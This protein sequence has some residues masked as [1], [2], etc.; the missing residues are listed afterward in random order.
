MRCQLTLSPFLIDQTATEEDYVVRP[1][2]N[3]TTFTSGMR[4]FG[5]ANDAHETNKEAVGATL[6]VGSTTELEQRM[7]PK[8][9]DASFRDSPWLHFHSVKALVLCTFSRSLDSITTSAS[10]INLTKLANQKACTSCMSVS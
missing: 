3:F 10:T 1:Q 8:F 2:Q 7:L 6:P 5:T 9:N 4:S